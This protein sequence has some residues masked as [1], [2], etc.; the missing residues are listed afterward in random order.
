MLA[1]GPRYF[2]ALGVRMLRGRA[3]AAADGEPGREAMI[4]NQRLADM[5]FR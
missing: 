5:H 4:I 3:F 1:V 2:D